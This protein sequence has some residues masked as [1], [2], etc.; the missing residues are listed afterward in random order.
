MKNEEK[1]TQNFQMKLV[2]PVWLNTSSPFQIDFHD[3]KHKKEHCV[4]VVTKYSGMWKRNELV[5]QK[6]R[7]LDLIQKV[8]TERLQHANT[9][10]DFLF[11]LDSP[12]LAN[13]SAL[14][15]VL[16]SSTW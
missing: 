12:S 1:W 9:I 11:H 2:S 5:R 4:Q 7:W 8:S 10:F 16:T 6:R 3:Q 15:F 14:K 13:S